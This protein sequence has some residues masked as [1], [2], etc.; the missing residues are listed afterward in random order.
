MTMFVPTNDALETLPEGMFLHMLDD[1]DYTVEILLYHTVQGVILFRDD[2]P[3]GI[4]HELEMGNGA[5][6]T[7]LCFVDTPLYQVGPG[8][9]DDAVPAFLS[10]DFTMC[11]GVV[12]KIDHFLLY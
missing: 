4:D 9:T 7:T 2:L 12:H 1:M 6:S 11:N 3:C 10:T 5:T 8:N